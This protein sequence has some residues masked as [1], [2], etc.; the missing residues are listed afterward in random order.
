MN[1]TI[2]LLYVLIGLF[3]LVPGTAFGQHEVS[4]TVVDSTTGESLPGV[5]I[6]VD[7]TSRGTTTDAEGNFELTAPSAS[8]TLV[9]SFVGYASK[10]IPIQGR[11]QID[12]GLVPSTLETEELVVVGYGT[13]QQSDIT[14]SVSVAEPGQLKRSS[15]SSLAGAL[16][17]QVAGV[18][19]QTSG[20]PGENPA[21]QIRGIGT[22]G[23]TSPLYVVDG[24]PVDNIIDFNVNNIES[25]QVMK[26][27]AASAIY[28]SRA[29]NGVVIIETNSGS[30]EGGLQVQYD[31]SVGTENIHQRIDV[32]GR[33]NFQEF[34]NKIRR[35]AGEPPAPANDPS[36]P[37]YVDDINTD[38][39]DAALDRGYST[40][41][42][43]SVSGG[44]ETSTYSL[45]GGYSSQDGHMQGPAPHYER[46]TARINST[47]DLGWLTLG[48]NLALTHSQNKPQTSR[49]ENSLFA[50]VIKAPPTIPVYDDSRLGGYGGADTGEEEAIALNVV[51]ANNLLERRQDVNRILAN[52][53]GEAQIVEDLTYK[54]NASYDTRSY[55]ERF[56]TPTYDL[57]FFYQEQDGRLDE[58]RNELVNTTLENTL[59]YDPVFGEHDLNVLAGYSEERSWFSDNIARGI[60]YSRPFFKVINQA[61]TRESEGSQTR[62]ALRSFFGRLQYN[63]GDRYLLTASIR[64]DGSSRFVEDNRYGNFP[65]VS[66]GWRISEE[67][68]FNVSAVDDLK[69]RASWGQLGRQ[70]T[71]DFATEAFI[72]TNA[73]YN[74]ND[75]IANGA[76]QVNLANPSLKWETQVSRTV[77]ID[78]ALFDNTLDFTVE[79]YR[80]E[81]Q[82]II[83]A[84]PIPTSMGA[85]EN[86]DANGATV[87]NS[88][89][90]VSIGY[91]NTA[92]DF[93]YELSTNVSTINNEVLSLGN[94]EPIFGA[95]SRTAVGSEIGEIYG[96]VTDGLFQNQDEV[97]NHATQE[98][99]TAPGDIRFKDLNGD[100]VITE[101]D[102]RTYLGSPTPD[103]TYGF[104]ANLQYQGWDASFFL[105][106]N[107]GNKIF[108]WTRQYVENMR[109]FNNSSVRAYENHWTP[110]NKHNDVRFPRAVFN[111]PNENI[112][113]SDRW[114][115]DGSYMRLKNLTIGYSLPQ[116]LVDRV[117][118]SNLRIYVAGENLYTLTGYSG[119]DPELGTNS[120]DADNNNIA[121]DGLFSRGYADAAWPH[122][123]RFETGVEVTF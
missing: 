28:G 66:A 42:N 120:G 111:D 96:F 67:S 48:E 77:G 1:V 25:V 17:G 21:I 78:A 2:R 76:I 26:D 105:Q 64:R 14:G 103:F 97:D 19:V 41:H 27:A 115:E 73:N 122:P 6:V 22:F 100:G 81:S 71:G 87:E 80:N 33:E 44:G 104:S 13:Q 55:H 60:G 52:A 49:W 82:D 118:M 7:G 59:T 46:Y 72:N 23:D 24:V 51:G 84:V 101:E 53:W 74:F 93:N 54:L 69:V 65:S 12:V 98:P 9:F 57:G 32:L 30:D 11:S 20:A 117:G 123:R 37:E 89:F 15:Q 83:V 16:E 10:E 70:Q 34:N 5:N 3:L 91:S 29:A 58:F 4:G 45:S 121:N 99:G 62:S 8:G 95:A 18:Q 50:E 109:D 94:G 102:D 112:R 116:S 85:A 61:D 40:E 39:Q 86:P 68:F 56:F 47:H 31:A 79:Y 43:L 63:Y 113:A 119:L 36:S 75:Q 114:V 106:G 107:Y 92:G 110:D 108:N 90:D 38:W 88:G 35:N